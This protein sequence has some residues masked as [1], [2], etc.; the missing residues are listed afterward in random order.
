MQ[1]NI[2]ILPV[3]LNIVFL[4]CTIK[5]LPIKKYFHHPFIF[6]TSK[7]MSDSDVIIRHIIENEQ[8]EQCYMTTKVNT[9]KS[10]IRKFY[11]CYRKQ[12]PSHIDI[13]YHFR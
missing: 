12:V 3:L 2:G 8:G 9:N 7:V 13:R 11:D 1:I 6:T 5:L 10:G 4:Y